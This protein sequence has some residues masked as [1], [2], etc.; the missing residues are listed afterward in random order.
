ML[1]SIV[2]NGFYL[3]GFM[4]FTSFSLGVNIMQYSNA[5]ISWIYRLFFEKGKLVYFYTFLA[6]PSLDNSNVDRIHSDTFVFLY[7]PAKDD[8][9]F[10]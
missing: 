8:C 9:G 10:I 7:D 4:I 3:L 2:V 5:K 6:C 1:T